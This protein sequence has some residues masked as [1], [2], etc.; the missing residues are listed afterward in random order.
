MDILPTCGGPIEQ[1]LEV[2]FWELGLD[3]GGNMSSEPFH[4]GGTLLAGD[5]VSRLGILPDGVGGMCK[6]R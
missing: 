4:G 6:A 5:G 1:N 3:G 2:L